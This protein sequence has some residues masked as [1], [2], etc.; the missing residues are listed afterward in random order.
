[1]LPTETER[2]T[3]MKVSHTVVRARRGIGRFVSDTLPRIEIARVRPFEEVP[4]TKSKSSAFKS[5]SAR[6]PNPSHPASASTPA[7][8]AGSGSP[9]SST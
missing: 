8:T 6:P 4:D 1:M 9:F 5:K 3:D 7:A 2:G